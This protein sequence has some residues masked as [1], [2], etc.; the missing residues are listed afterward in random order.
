MPTCYTENGLRYIQKDRIGRVAIY[1]EAHPEGLVSP[2]FVVAVI[3]EKQSPPVLGNTIPPIE[4]MPLAD[5]WGKSAFYY[6]GFDD[7]RNKMSE[8][9][10]DLRTKKPVL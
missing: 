4:N 8:L 6:E 5:Q 3:C 10:Y 2:M 7:A 9:L 1:E